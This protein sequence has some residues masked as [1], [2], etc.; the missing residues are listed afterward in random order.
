MNAV[1]FCFNPGT[2]KMHG[3]LI[4]FVVSEEKFSF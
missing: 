1:V 4:Q 3:L 2:Q